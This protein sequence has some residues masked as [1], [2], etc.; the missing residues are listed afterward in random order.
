MLIFLSQVLRQLAIVLLY[1]GD[2]CVALHELFFD[3]FDFLRV[4]KCILRLDDFLKLFSKP[5]TLLDVDLDFDLDLIRL[6]TLHIPLE[7]RDFFFLPR[8]LRVQLYYLA[9]EARNKVRLGLKAASFLAERV[10]LKLER[11]AK[12]EVGLFLFDHEIVDDFV[13]FEQL[14][15]QELNL[16]LELDALLDDSI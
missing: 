8:N 15:L 6:C 9:L 10:F 1:F 4:R 2:H 5:G 12:T 16:S 14:R 11:H 7:H 3:Y 13:A